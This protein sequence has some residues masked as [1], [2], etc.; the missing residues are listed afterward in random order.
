MLIHGHLI[1]ATD[2]GRLAREARL[3][4]DLT[5]AQVA[6]RLGVS[7]SA[8]AHAETEKH[9][10]GSLVRL[11]LRIISELTEFSTVGPFYMI[12]EKGRVLDADDVFLS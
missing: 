7:Q 8:V 5:Q 10:R 9:R 6:E 11:Q 12:K 4:A 1:P 2:L 3:I